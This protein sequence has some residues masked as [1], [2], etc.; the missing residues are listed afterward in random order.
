MTS[1]PSQIYSVVLVEDD[2]DVNLRLADMIDLHS[3]F[4]LCAS[5]SS[6]E[7]GRKALLG[8]KPDILLTDIGLPDG[9]GIDIIQHIRVHRL[10][11]EA[12]VI[13]GFQDEKIVFEALK[14][15]AKGYVLK[16][17]EDQ[18]TTDAMLTLMA[19]GAPISPAIARYLLNQFHSQ[20]TTSA[21][22]EILTERQARIL[23]LVCQGFSSREIGEKLDI[24]Y[25]TVTTHIKNIYQKLQVNSRSEVLHEALKLGLY[26]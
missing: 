8:Y 22:L 18:T 3:S 2:P 21:S 11:T 23:K 15:G 6:M 19:G 14:A 26:K 1:N 10:D 5:A 20:E 16:H 7:E 9:S 13:S 24:S 17:D 25:Y 12:M 4:K